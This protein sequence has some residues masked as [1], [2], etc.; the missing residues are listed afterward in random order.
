MIHRAIF[1]AGAN[2]CFAEKHFRT[3]SWSGDSPTCISYVL[4][5]S[6]SASI[7]V[8]ETRL[9]KQRNRCILS[10]LYPLCVSLI[11]F[12]KKGSEESMARNYTLAKSTL[13]QPH[14][15]NVY[16]KPSTTPNYPKITTGYTGQMFCR[17]GILNILQVFPVKFAK[18]LKT[19]ILKNIW[20]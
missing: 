17:K 2:G 5:I 11:F 4:N 3:F 13:V 14:F 7:L 12:N 9:P 1:R 6:L 15:E 16:K 8:V 10:H 18:F 20:E 19:P